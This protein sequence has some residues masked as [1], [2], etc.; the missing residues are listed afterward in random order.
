M[1][2]LNQR[3]CESATRGERRI[4]RLYRHASCIWHVRRSTKRSHCRCKSIKRCLTIFIIDDWNLYKTCPG[5]AWKNSIIILKHVLL[6]QC[7]NMPWHFRSSRIHR[8]GKFKI[9]WIRNIWAHFTSHAK[10]QNNCFKIY[11]LMS[12]LFLP[13]KCFEIHKEPNVGRV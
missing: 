3:F 12:F 6:L 4:S 2:A 1:K 10:N 7:S 5:A 8:E 9:N 11:K 13:L